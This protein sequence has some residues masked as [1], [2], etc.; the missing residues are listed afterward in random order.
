MY[1]NY[2]YFNYFTTLLSDDFVVFIWQ[3]S[4]EQHLSTALYH[5]L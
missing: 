2:L 5:S 1:F 3:V 4:T